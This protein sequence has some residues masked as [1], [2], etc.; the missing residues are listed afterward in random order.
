MPRPPSWRPI[1]EDI[2]AMSRSWPVRPAPA[3][4]LASTFAA[5]GLALRLPLRRGAADLG[6]SGANLPVA[7]YQAR[8]DRAD[9]IT[10]FMTGMFKVSDPSAARGN[11]I[12]ARE[13]LD[14]ASKD[15]DTGLAKDPV[16]SGAMMQSHGGRIRRA[17]D[18][19]RKHSLCWQ[20]AGYPTPRRGAIESRNSH[21]EEASGLGY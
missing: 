4:G 18:C 2:C 12:T 19:T 15:I 5:I 3:T 13:I 17:L 10:E 7:A 8:A 9:R 20:S 11:S 14:K 1:S 16:L 21:L 6:G